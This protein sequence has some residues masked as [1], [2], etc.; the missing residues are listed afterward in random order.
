MN[1]KQ[2]NKLNM[3]LTVKAVL[4]DH[5]AD[6]QTVAAFVDQAKVFNGKLDTITAIA[7][8]QEADRKGITVDKTQ[9]QELLIDS[10]MIGAGIVRAFATVTKQ[11]DLKAQVSFT[12]SDVDHG[13]DTQI[14]TRA[15]LVMSLTESNATALKAYG[16]TADVA[17]ELKS[18]KEAY[19]AVVSAPRQSIGN[20]KVLT[21]TLAGL[22][23][24]TDA[25]LEDVLDA[26]ALQFETSA[27]T[28]T[29]EYE[30]ARN[31]VNHGTRHVKPAPTPTPAPVVKGLTA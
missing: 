31:V 26:L 22:F 27:P 20:R 7:Q 13:T 12:R 6:Y 21:D 30:Q 18:R 24:E 29:A 2:N 16:W 4:T 9:L 19:D 25:L 15:G 23:D 1:S 5:T 17:A 10:V 14:S 11:A 3:Y 28:F 8:A